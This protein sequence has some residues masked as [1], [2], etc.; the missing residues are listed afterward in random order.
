[1]PISALCRPTRLRRHH[2]PQ[3]P[4]FLP[5]APTS[6]SLGPQR[7]TPSPAC[8]TQNRRQPRAHTAVAPSRRADER[9][10]APRVVSVQRCRKWVLHPGRAQPIQALR[11]ILNVGR[12]TKSCLHCSVCPCPPGRAV[13]LELG[14]AVP[15]S[16]ELWIDPVA[17]WGAGAGRRARDV[18]WRARHCPV[19]RPAGPR[20][21]MLLSSF[22]YNC[23]LRPLSPWLITR[24]HNHMSAAPLPDVERSDALCVE[25]RQELPE[26]HL[27][28]R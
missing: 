2:R 23:S 9:P 1:M 27:F 18:G 22:M 7:T 10:T 14:S 3:T 5:P 24:S 26:L 16:P 6:I 11:C 17:C 12:V 21:A 8:S 25:E 28:G 13:S 19:A 4:T 15:P 20:G